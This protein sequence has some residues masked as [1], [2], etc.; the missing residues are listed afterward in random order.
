M[1]AADEAGVDSILDAIDVAKAGMIVFLEL[2]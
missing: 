2:G 1:R